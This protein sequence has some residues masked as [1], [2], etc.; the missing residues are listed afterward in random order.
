MNSRSLPNKI[1]IS[2]LFIAI[3]TIFGT[4]SIPV[5]GAKMSPI[6][7]FINVV[8]AVVLGPVYAVANAFI[9][10]VLRNIIG[11][12]SILAFPGSM[13]GALIAGIIYKKFRRI[14]GALI[15]EIIGTGILGALVAYPIA[16]LFLG[17]DVALFAFVIPFSVSCI[18]GALIAYI[19]LKVPAIRR[20]LLEREDMR[21]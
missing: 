3:A 1:A 17:K 15:G 9:T 13:I 10:S 4:F 5:F 18:C 21:K 12:G 19:F 8:S 14:E 2:G 20:L 6:Q 7:H 16:G 11:T